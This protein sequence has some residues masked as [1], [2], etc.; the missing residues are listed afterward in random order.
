[1]KTKATKPATSAT[2][3][4]RRTPS[5][6]RAQFT[7]DAIVEAAQL[8]LAEQGP[9]AL[10]TRRI[11]ERAGVSIGSLYQ[12][13][14]NRESIIT[15]LFEP[16]LLA[17]AEQGCLRYTQP[18]TT[19]EFFIEAYRSQIALAKS[20]ANIDSV[21]FAH[22][23]KYL[24]WDWFAE[25]LGMSPQRRRKNIEQFL[26]S[27]HPELGGTE[28]ELASFML[29]ITLPSMLD[30]LALENPT[31]LNEQTLSAKLTDM[32]KCV[33]VSPTENNFRSIAAARF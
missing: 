12:Y 20:L 26:R 4:H 30:S 31:L 11:A 5:Q 24:M 1:M 33:L 3:Y 32:V 10:N 9:Q 13:F 7:V 14:P 29:A 18:L 15:R 27:R 8:L 16:L 6:S 17:A 23:Q 22:H 21:T 28:L 19:E 25:K 2:I